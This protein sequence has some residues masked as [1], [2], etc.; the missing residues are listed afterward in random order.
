M[1]LLVDSSLCDDA[2]VRPTSILRMNKES[3]R[4]VKARR[5]TKKRVRTETGTVKAYIRSRT[6]F[7]V[8]AKRYLSRQV[9]G[10]CVRYVDLPY[11]NLV[12]KRLSRPRPVMTLIV[13]V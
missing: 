12:N 2:F 6:A 3:Q 10:R 11:E 13:I 9:N 7:V 1:R 4:L 8:F 5:L